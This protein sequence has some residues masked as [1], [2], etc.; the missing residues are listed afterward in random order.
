LT[1]AGFIVIGAELVSVDSL[2]GGAVVDVEAEDVKVVVEEVDGVVVEVVD[3]VV[4]DVVEDV[5]LSV[6]KVVEVVV[7]SM[8]STYF[9]IKPRL[10]TE[11]SEEN[12]I[13]KVLPV[14]K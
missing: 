12:P 3:G 2:V 6:V 13:V 5:V 7:V 4:V 11:L 8:I 10:V 14:A 1:S 9:N